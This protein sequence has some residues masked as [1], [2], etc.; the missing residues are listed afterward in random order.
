MAF[1][2]AVGLVSVFVF[3]EQRLDV[4]FGIKHSCQALAVVISP[5]VNLFLSGCLLDIS[6]S[7]NTGCSGSG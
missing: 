1:S 4:L 5:L 2:V 6:P 3:F 7:V